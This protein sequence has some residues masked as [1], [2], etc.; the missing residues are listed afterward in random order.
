MH[1]VIVLALVL[2]AASVAECI[3][4]PLFGVR[5]WK[6]WRRSPEVRDGLGTPPPAFPRVSVVVPAHDEER[7]AAG[8][9]RSIL[10]SDWPDLELVFV[11]DRCSDGTEAALA[12][13]AAA[14]PRLRIVVN[15]EC[16]ADWAGKCNAA[17]V[18]AA[19]A[20][21]E[22]VL[23]ADADTRFDPQ[24]IRA[25]VGM[26]RARRLD[27]LSLWSSPRQERWFEQVVQPVTAIVM[28]KLFPMRRIDGALRRRPFA[29]GQFMLFDRRAYESFGGHAAVKDDLLEDL[30]F[31]RGMHHRGMRVDSAIADGMLTVA[32]YDAWPAFREGWKRIFIESCVRNPRRLAEQAWQLAAIGVVLP[33]ART[34]SLVLALAAVLAPDA[35]VDEGATVL[36]KL[37]VAVAASAALLRLGVIAFAYRLGR[38]PVWAS[39]LFPLATIAV[40]RILLAGAAD[41]R[42]RVPIRWGGRSYVL[43]PSK[44]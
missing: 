2:S 29:N 41:L 4:W 6:E 33:A 1:T 20:T 15:R 31:A 12:P 9:A 11:L 22:L 7:V 26:M 44:A 35:S 13:V 43:E 38:F 21:G 40:A 27:M 23:F 24:L 19:H 39:V 17:R 10:A 18:G 28:L 42:N 5:A 36:A 34:A 25:A 8:C 32:M 3:A 16:P 30:A 14:D 37:A